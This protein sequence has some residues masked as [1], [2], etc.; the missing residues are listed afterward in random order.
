MDFCLDVDVIYSFHL[1]HDMP[2]YTFHSNLAG[3]SLNVAKSP[4]LSGSGYA[5]NNSSFLFK[6]PLK[7]RL[8]P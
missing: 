1:L 8:Q 3:N 6:T 7:K 2:T 4:S 5:T